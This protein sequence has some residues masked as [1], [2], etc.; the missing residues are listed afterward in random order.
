MDLIELFELRGYPIERKECVVG[1]DQDFGGP[2]SGT[3]VPM[4]LTNPSHG[5]PSD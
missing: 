5:V 2:A 4:W 1:K 3:P